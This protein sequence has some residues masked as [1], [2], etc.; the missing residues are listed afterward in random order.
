MN[1][2]I[3][4]LNSLT[5]YAKGAGWIWRKSS[6]TSSPFLHGWQL[7][8]ISLL[9]CKG[10]SYCPEAKDFFVWAPCSV[11]ALWF[12]TSTYS[13]L[14]LGNLKPQRNK[15]APPFFDVVKI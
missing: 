6:L 3:L 14:G 11:H 9:R 2:A 4:L 7:N 13:A 8:Q 15:M 12:I 10:S 1:F 5:N